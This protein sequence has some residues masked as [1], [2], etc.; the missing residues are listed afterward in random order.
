MQAEPNIL[1][2]FEE[3][4]NRARFEIKRLF[5]DDKNSWVYSVVSV[6]T[7][8]LTDYFKANSGSKR[9]LATNIVKRINRNL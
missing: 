6:K 3:L 2:E 5:T 9:R 1:N 4:H 8:Y 7:H